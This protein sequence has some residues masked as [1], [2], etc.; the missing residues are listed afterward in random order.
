VADLG[1]DGLGQ[2]RT[3]YDPVVGQRHT[4][5][6]A[7]HF[8]PMPTAD[9]RT[10]TEPGGAIPV[11]PQGRAP[12]M[13]RTPTHVPAHARTPTAVTP[14][15]RTPTAVTPQARTP[16]A[17]TPQARTPDQRTPP[18]VRAPDHRTPPP[19]GAPMRAQSDRTPPPVDRRAGL[20]FDDEDLAS[21]MSPAQIYELRRIGTAASQHT[22]AELATFARAG[23]IAPDDVLVQ[24]TT[25]RQMLV[26]DVPALREALRERGPAAPIG[27]RP[28]P[29][30]VVPPLMITRSRRP[31]PLVWVVMALAVVFVGLGVFAWMRFG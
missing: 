27:P 12:T 2:R 6:D 20:A 21:N 23:R 30:V 11:D 3:P 24:T 13:N 26:A 22:L 14:Q 5:T 25:G 16:T 9:G 10:P 7:D 19:V 4:P 31:S 8:G 1:F 15:A 17:V 28:P 18:P 29:P